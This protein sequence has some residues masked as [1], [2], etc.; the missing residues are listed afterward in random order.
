VSAVSGSSQPRGTDSSRRVGHAQFGNAE[1]LDRAVVEA[2]GTFALIAGHQL[3]L[4]FEG[5]RLQQEHRALIGR[6]GGIHPRLIDRQG[7][8]GG[9]ESDSEGRD[10]RPDDD[11]N[12]P[13]PRSIGLVLNFHE[14]ST[15]RTD[16]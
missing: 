11:A 10:C 5:H 7:G 13:R 14:P 16:P 9:Y 1:T 2:A 6:Q 8:G 12:S 15:L 3:D 4:L